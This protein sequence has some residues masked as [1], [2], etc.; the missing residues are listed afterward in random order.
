VSY[1]DK[2]D[3]RVTKTQSYNPQPVI[4]EVISQLL[5]K[6]QVKSGSNLRPISQ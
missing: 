1:I 3:W 5:Q 6:V 4:I 2:T